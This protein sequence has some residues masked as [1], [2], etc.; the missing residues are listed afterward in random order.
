[1]RTL[2]HSDEETRR[3]QRRIHTAM[4][5]FD[6]HRHISDTEGLN[7]LAVH[8]RQKTPRRTHTRRRQRRLKRHVGHEQNTSCPAQTEN[9]SSYTDRRCLAEHE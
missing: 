6:G 3:T 2:Q 1:M 9:V 7:R 4:K 8:S 5:R